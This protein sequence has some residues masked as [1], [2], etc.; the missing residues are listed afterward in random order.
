VAL[1]QSSFTCL[2]DQTINSRLNE[3]VRLVLHG[4][5]RGGAFYRPV[6]HHVVPFWIGCFILL[7][8][9]TFAKSAMEM[10]QSQMLKCFY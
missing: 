3:Q 7:R 5:E 4:N 6:T 2:S 9:A 10:R 1:K 8:T